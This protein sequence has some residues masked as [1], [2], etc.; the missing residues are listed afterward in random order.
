[1]IKE[2][3]NFGLREHLLTGATLWLVSSLYLTV[4]TLIHFYLNAYFGGLNAADRL[5]A[6]WMAIWYNLS[7]FFLIAVIVTLILLLLLRGLRLPWGKSYRLHLWVFLL[8]C[9][10]L[11]SNQLL[12]F[13]IFGGPRDPKFLAASI[14]LLVIAYLFLLLVSKLILKIAASVGVIASVLLIVAASFPL[15]PGRDSVSEAQDLRS[16]RPNILLLSIDTLRGDHCSFNGYHR[17]TTPNLD[18][19]AEESVVFS[20]AFSCSPIT[21]PSLSSIMTGKYPQNHGARDNLNYLLS[22]KNLTLAEI[23]T[24]EGYTTGAVV[25]NR[26]IRSTRKLNQGFGYYGESF[27]YDQ[28]SYLIPGL[29]ARKVFLERTG[30]ESLWHWKLGA[31]YCTDLALRWL[32]MHHRERFFLWVHYMDPHCPYDPPKVFADKFET[33]GR[34]WF[35]ANFTYGDYNRIYENLPPTEEEIAG[36]HRLYDGEILYTDHEIGRFMETVER[37]GLLENTV[38]IFTS[39]HG[40]GLGDEHYWYGGHTHFLF[41]EDL[42]VPLFIRFPDRRSK[43]TVNT[44]LSNIDI[45]ATVLDIVGILEEYSEGI[46]AVSALP[47]TEGTGDED[48]PPIFAES[49]ERLAFDPRRIEA[50]K[51]GGENPYRLVPKQK[52]SLTRELGLEVLN[53]KKLRAVIDGEWKLMYTPANEEREHFELY[54]LRKDPNEYVDFSAEQP[55]RFSRLKN[56]LLSW[57]RADTLTRYDENIEISREE[58]QALKALGYIQ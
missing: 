56:V 32:K 39:D 54:N 53:E 44:T 10:L 47:V 13:R 48:P 15:L 50:I 25:A 16:G 1:M 6:I 7:F 31:G 58:M 52:R 49:G 30:L 46:D 3:R 41:S 4:L 36:I 35:T 51:E 9:F 38:I 8:I 26:V 11:Q 24:E 23:L 42:N 29:L 28:L 43:V 55:L 45:F 57:V 18:R 34:T 33:S 17:R 21:L 20:N 12:K 19:L 40:E 27:V 14:I 2:K 22:E 5:L 37:L